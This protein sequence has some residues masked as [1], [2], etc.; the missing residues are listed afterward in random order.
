MTLQ[1]RASSAQVP[2]F[3]SPNQFNRLSAL[4]W[5]YE[6]KTNSFHFMCILGNNEGVAFDAFVEAEDGNTLTLY[7]NEFS[8]GEGA[9]LGDPIC[10]DKTT[11][12]ENLERIVQPYLLRCR[13]DGGPCS[14]EVELR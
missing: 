13:E 10:A 7:Y 4:G 8:F 12:L 3:L 2:P 11:T 5:A 9:R 6:S 14:P 1:E